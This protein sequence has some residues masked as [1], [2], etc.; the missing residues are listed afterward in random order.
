MDS[1]T[2]E[3][4]L[5]PRSYQSV[6]IVFPP[7]ARWGLAPSELHKC[8]YLVC[9]TPW[10]GG[11]LHPRS[12]ES[13]IIHSVPLSDQ[14][15]LCTL[16]VTKVLPFV[17]LSLPRSVAP[18]PLPRWVIASSKFPKCCNDPPGKGGVNIVDTYGAFPSVF[19]RFIIMPTGLEDDTPVY[20]AMLLRPCSLPL[21]FLCSPTFP[22]HFFSR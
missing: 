3:K 18:P 20:L 21:S 17:I 2:Y 5:R 10:P 19:V 1:K 13:V 11:P 4:S 9:S 14:V 12:H 16:K 8:S 22:A 6:A 7:L 15:W